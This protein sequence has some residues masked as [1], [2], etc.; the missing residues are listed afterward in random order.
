MRTTGTGDL[1]CCGA[2]VEAAEAMSYGLRTWED[3]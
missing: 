3:E 1:L 2:G